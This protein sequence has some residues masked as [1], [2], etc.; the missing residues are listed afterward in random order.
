MSEFKLFYFPIRGRA[1]LARIAFELS[2]RK[3]IDN[4]I[5]PTI[6]KDLKK[7]LTENGTLAF[8]QVPLLEHNGKKIVQSN[9][10]LRYLG[11]EYIL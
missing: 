11:R 6:W 4:E 7:E 2:G 1:E 3:Y 9:T 8:G 10:I 5:E